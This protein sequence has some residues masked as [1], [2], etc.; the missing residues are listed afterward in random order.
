MDEDVY[1]H[2]AGRFFKSLLSGANFC[3]CNCDAELWLWS[4][5]TSTDCGT[6]ED[7]NESRT[8]CAQD[9]QTMPQKAMW[10]SHMMWCLQVSGSLGDSVLTR[11]CWTWWQNWT[12]TLSLDFT[13]RADWLL[14]TKRFYAVIQYCPLLWVSGKMWFGVWQGDM[15]VW[16]FNWK[17]T[18]QRRVLLISIIHSCFSPLWSPN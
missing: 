14:I 10:M 1:L 2:L 15:L 12:E 13:F 17:I 4:N 3:P 7:P 18:I 5:V 16:T 11:V 8:G 6:L 9:A